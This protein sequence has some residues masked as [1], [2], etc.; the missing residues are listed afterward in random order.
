[1]SRSPSLLALTWLMT[2]LAV[3][4]AGLAV[5]LAP[6][7]TTVA[8][9]SFGV[10]TA[11]TSITGPFA[12]S[13]AVLA[14]L[15]LILLTS[16][17]R[18]KNRARPFGELLMF[19]P[20]LFAFIWFLLP[21]GG[22]NLRTIIILSAFVLAGWYLH[23]HSPGPISRNRWQGKSATLMLDAGLVLLPVLAGY[24]L[25]FSPDLKAGVL[26]LLLYPAYALVQLVLFLHIPISRLRAMGV[27]PA[28]STLFTSLVFSLVHWPNPLVM[29]VTLLGMLIWA[30][31]F[32]NG[33]SLW[34]LA[35]VLGLTATTFSQFIPDDLTRHVRVGPGYI[36]AEAVLL[37]AEQ[38][39]IGNP[40]EFIELFY[41]QTM[42]RQVLPEELHTWTTLMNEARRST[43][44][45]M[46]LTSGENRR[47]L[48]KAHEEVP[49]VEAEHWAL[50]PRQ[51]KSKIAA[52]ASEDYW[53][54]SGKTQ[55]TYLKALYMD[56]LGR[57]ETPE[58][59]Q[60]WRKTLSTPQRQRIAEVLLE[61]RLQQG[62]AVFTGMDVEDFRFPN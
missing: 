62:Q 37:L 41:P 3:L 51:W 40:S 45:Y 50:W 39:E 54:K 6:V 34:Q 44:A 23:R 12:L 48:A 59:L 61:L 24:A 33:R 17:A 20:L 11:A 53:Q 42:G 46:F 28:N 4:T 15:L 16:S 55:D 7:E 58:G 9:P 1:M 56:I 27:S 36:R 8:W 30:H 2:C 49:P 13:L 43:W 22:L 29:L 10:W 35:L 19:F 60:L 5:R 31:Q 52:F 57:Q 14:G 32:Q 26:S 18:E 38:T 25:G 47:R 21:A